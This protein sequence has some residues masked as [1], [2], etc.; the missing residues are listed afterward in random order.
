MRPAR[1]RARRRCEVECLPGLDEIVCE[2]IAALLPGQA[3]VGESPRPGRLPVQTLC[4]PWELENL[5]CAVAGHLSLLFEVPRPKALLGH[6]HFTRLLALVRQV[7]GRRPAGAFS[8]VRISAAGADS[9]VFARLRAELERELRLSGS[10]DGGDLLLSFRRPADGSPG[11]EVLVRT[12]PLP[13]SARSWRVCSMP[14]ALNATV[15]Q[16]M[17]RLAQPRPDD[18]FL[19]LACGSGTF[20][21]ERLQTVPARQALGL[22][23]RPDA[24][25]CARA[26]LEAG[27]CAPRARLLHADA[28]AVP[29]P[30]E[31]MD[32]LVVD[33]PFGMLVS[34]A[35]EIRA[36]YPALLREGA[37]VARPGAALVAVTAA[38]RLFEACVACEP[39]WRQERSLAVRLPYKDREMTVGVYLLRR[40]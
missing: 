12:T 6:Q 8:A 34:S 22:D 18:R 39:A 26:N 13:L 17:V 1:S 29:L 3:L 36:L 14:G 28:T 30:S 25:Q 32:T 11:W 2:E 7:A 31:S 4:P 23:I 16:A 15:A 21:V 20:L 40:A 24:L 37:R 10:T 38:R 19:N 9:A 35:D 27:G 5:H 33:L